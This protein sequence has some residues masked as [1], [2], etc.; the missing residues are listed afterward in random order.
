[1]NYSLYNV[2]HKTYFSLWNIS[3]FSTSLTKAPITEKYIAFIILFK[4]DVFSS[5]LIQGKMLSNING[6][7]ER[8]IIQNTGWTET[9][10]PFHLSENVLL[11]SLQT[12]HSAEKPQKIT[13]SYGI[14]SIPP[15]PHLCGERTTGSQS[16]QHSSYLR[17]DAQKPLL[18]V[19]SRSSKWACG[20]Q[21][22]AVGYEG[23]L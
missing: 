20:K 8:N 17:F 23:C 15:D 12:W 5:A 9:H 16:H 21:M 6:T 2:L 11:T 14:E 18:W 4:C 10:S 22:L 7:D 3:N 1:M 13:A 19:S